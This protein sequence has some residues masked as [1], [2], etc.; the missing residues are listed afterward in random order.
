VLAFEPDPKVF[1]ILTG[2]IAANGFGRRMKASASALSGREG[3]AQLYVPW[4]NHGVV[5]TS[6]SLEAAFKERHQAVIDVPVTTIDRAV[7]G[8]SGPTLIKIDV[9]GHELAVLTGAEATLAAHRP[10]VLIELLANTDW[11]GLNA[12][13]AKHGYG[14]VSLPRRAVASPRPSHSTPTPGIR[15]SV[16]SNC[17]RCSRPC[18]RPRSGARTPRYILNTPKRGRSGTGAFSAAL[19]DRP[20]TSRVWAGSM[21]PSSHRRAVAK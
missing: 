6:S 3:T 9:E 21:M 17:G 5:E 13:A 10:M 7:A 4:D 16:R 15:C 2:N 19:M 12:V 14:G 1:P 18:W 11:A 8:G 20:S